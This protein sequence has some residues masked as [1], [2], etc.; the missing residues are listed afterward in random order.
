VIVLFVAGGSDVLR[1]VG[2]STAVRA[3]P[4]V[5]ALLVLPLIAHAVVRTFELEPRSHFQTLVRELR[6]RRLPGEPIY[7]FARTLPAWTFYST[8]WAHPDTARLRFLMRSAGSTGAAFENAP[9][10]GRVRDEEEIAVRPSPA[11][12]GELL[13]L[14]SGMEWREVQEHVRPAPDSGWVE[15]ERRRIEDAATP[16][17]WVLATA[18]YGA[19]RELFARLEREAR[20]RTF[21]HL[22]PGSALVR[23]DFGPLVQK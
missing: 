11:A 10:R 7:V 9:S 12:P 13:G 23:Y 2:E 21:A 8:D 3:L 1:L 19:E 18:W 4:A 15:T 20:R 22:R 6:K 14:P 17:V 16:G 5:T